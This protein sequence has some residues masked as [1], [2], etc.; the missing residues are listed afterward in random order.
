L[1]VQRMQQFLVRQLMQA[2]EFDVVDPRRLGRE[3]SGSD[4]EQA[5][6]LHKS[7]LTRR[8]W[9]RGTHLRISRRTG[10][11]RFRTPQSASEQL[12]P[13]PAAKPAYI[14]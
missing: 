3:E 7:I 12:T 13:N 6:G 11:V 10:R 14:S 9:A 5:K 1:K 8:R 2:I 4:E